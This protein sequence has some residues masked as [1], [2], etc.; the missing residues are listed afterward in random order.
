M[1]P[2]AGLVLGGVLGFST[3]TERLA[4]AKGF[5]FLM[6]DLWRA[7]GRQ[8]QVGKSEQA[9]A[10]IAAEA[11][12]TKGRLSDLFE[13]SA[14]LIDAEKPWMERLRAAWERRRS[15]TEQETQALSAAQRLRD[16][17]SRSSDHKPVLDSGPYGIAVFEIASPR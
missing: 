4:P 12:I 11:E 2:I 14:S 1:A 10:D 5:Q 17:L 6:V 16:L 9:L 3:V 8:C 7:A 15:M 13:C